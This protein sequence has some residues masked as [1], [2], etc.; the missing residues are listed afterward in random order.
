MKP[1]G[2]ESLVKRCLRVVELMAEDA[3][4]MRL[5]EIAAKLKLAKSGC[6]RLLSLMEDAGWIEQDKDT[7]F[8][9]LTLK[10]AVVGQLFFIATHIPDICQPVLERLAAQTQALARLALVEGKGMTWVSHAQ[11]AQTG[12]LYQPA[13]AARV[14][15]HATATG[16][17]Y[18]ASLPV[19]E[20]VSLTI[21]AGFGQA[22]KMGPRAIRTVE[23]LLAELEVVRQ[24]GWALNDEEV[25]R[26]VRAVA[27]PVRGRNDAVVAAVAL[28]GPALHLS[29]E[30][31]P[32]LVRLTIDAANDMAALWPLRSLRIEGRVGTQK[33]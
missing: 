2:T 16:R 17:C 9:R 5:G 23:H 31:I 24:R 25:E 29:D 15:L 27:A 26:G 13:Q 14:P 20:A 6:H 19:D 12:L 4:A 30:R 8:Y 22:E 28:A 1:K 7:G 33:A 32:E 18:L 11:G 3:S 10:L 21:R